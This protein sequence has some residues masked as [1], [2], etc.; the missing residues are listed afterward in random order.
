[1]VAVV[2][3]KKNTAPLAGGH[4]SRPASRHNWWQDPGTFVP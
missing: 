2:I 1:M 4:H 3:E